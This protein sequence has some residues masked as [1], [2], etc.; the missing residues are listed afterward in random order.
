MKLIDLIPYLRNDNRLK[1]LYAKEK[2]NLESEAVLIY[3]TGSLK[4]ESE[5]TF[6]DIEE[7]EDDLYY[8]NNGI[9]YVQLFPINY[10]VELVNSWLE[11]Q[12]LSDQDIAKSLL[13][14]RI[15]DA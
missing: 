10:A 1:E 4:L 8:K 13:N 3:M 14:Y 12:D 11:V 2:L 6:F 7:T 5:L 15:K 9:S